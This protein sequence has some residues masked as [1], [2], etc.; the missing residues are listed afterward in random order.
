MLSTLHFIHCA[1][2]LFQQ[3]QQQSLFV[4][5]HTCLKLQKVTQLNKIFENKIGVLAA[6][7]GSQLTSPLN[8]IRIEV[9]KKI[10]A[11]MHTQEKKKRR[12]ETVFI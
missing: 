5:T 2:V 3:Q 1:Q 10:G 11:Q 9:S 6:S 8:K 4:L 7:T 12:N